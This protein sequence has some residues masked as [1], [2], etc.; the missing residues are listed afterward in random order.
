MKAAIKREH[1]ENIVALRARV[2]RLTIFVLVLGIYSYPAIRTTL[3]T[4]SRALPPISAPDLTLYLNISRIHESNS[5]QIID[6]YYGVA[7]PRVRLGYLKFRTSF[8]FFRAL[9][10]FLHNDLWLTVLVWNLFW[11]GLLC[12]VALW[13]FKE[14]LPD[15]SPLAP[16]AGL[17]GPEADR[18]Q[19]D[20]RGLSGHV[21]DRAVR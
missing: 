20:E 13:F 1:L 9:N 21:H 7:I 8:L 12:A 14:F 11:W 2:A 6:P 10:Q 16:V 17:A 5:G 19:P 4:R 18:P 15:R 3:A